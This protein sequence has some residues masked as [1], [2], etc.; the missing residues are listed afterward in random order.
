MRLIAR[1]VA[2]GLLMA[3]LLAGCK[4]TGK[5]GEFT[6]EFQAL[7]L[8]EGPAI[9]QRHYEQQ[10]AVPGLTVYHD[11]GKTYLLLRAG[12]VDQTGLGVQMLT[13]KPPVKGS[14]TVQVVA[15]LHEVTGQATAYPYALLLLEGGTDLTYKARLSN[16][17]EVPLE[18]PGIPLA[19]M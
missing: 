16:R 13:V 1:V 8:G 14:K 19:E 2:L 3:M 9:L 11:G 17:S 12:K 15:A 6:G 4:G 5:A 10:K 18:L 7:T